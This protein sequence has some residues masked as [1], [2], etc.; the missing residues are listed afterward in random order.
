MREVWY[1]IVHGPDLELAARQ[2]RFLETARIA[3]SILGLVAAG[4]RVEFVEADYRKL[5]EVAGGRRSGCGLPDEGTAIVL[6]GA[7]SEKCVEERRVGWEERGYEV[8]VEPNI[9]F[10]DGTLYQR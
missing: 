5:R 3:R 4:A 7:V 1:E 10:D 6:G 8:R 9:S 2:T